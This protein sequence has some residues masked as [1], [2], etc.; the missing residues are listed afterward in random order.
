MGVNEHQNKKHTNHA[1]DTEHSR[2]MAFVEAKG[3][4]ACDLC[5]KDMEKSSKGMNNTWHAMIA[6]HHQT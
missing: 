2:Q 4:D 3:W 6:E 5:R 1:V